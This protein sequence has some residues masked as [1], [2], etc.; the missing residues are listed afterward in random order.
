VGHLIPES[1][2]FSALQAL[3]KTVDKDI[4]RLKVNLQH[5]CN[6]VSDQRGDW[7]LGALLLLQLPPPG[8]SA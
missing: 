6:N 2:I 8:R 1:S 4:K 3:E 5:G 7:L